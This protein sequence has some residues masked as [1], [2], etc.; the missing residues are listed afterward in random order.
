MKQLAKSLV[1]AGALAVAG[2]AVAEFGD[3]NPY[4]G[5]DLQLTKMKAKAPFDSILSKS[6][7]GA[8]FYL[9]TKFHENFG[10]EAGYNWSKSQSRT[11]DVGARFDGAPGAGFGFGTAAQA[12]VKTKLRRNSAFFDVVGFLPVM[13]CVELIGSVGYGYVMPKL[14][15]QTAAGTAI[16]GYDLK[17]QSV[18]R[19]GLGASY[20]VTDM[21]GLRAKLGWEN[22]KHTH[23]KN[24]DDRKALRA[25]GG[26]LATRP[27]K[28][29]TTLNVGAF[30]KF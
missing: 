29:S 15:I 30:V 21:V 9:G 11:V 4:V 25:R 20:M 10:V 22:T 2:S 18:L 23:F 6:F 17:N 19:V 14:S 28:D 3:I 26:A 8:G 12:G 1:I 5:A 13:D 7:P 27:L 24:N 16:T